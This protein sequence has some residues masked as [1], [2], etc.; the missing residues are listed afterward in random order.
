M[1]RWTGSPEGAGTQGT[2]PAVLVAWVGREQS[3]VDSPQWGGCGKETPVP[4]TGR[5]TGGATGTCCEGE[6]E[7]GYGDPACRWAGGC[8]ASLSSAGG[9]W[10]Q[11]GWTTVAPSREALRELW[12]CA[13]RL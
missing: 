7:A 12:S 8:P 6:G 13:P 9:L 4:Y 10:G 2:C 11:A 3:K 5:W 1:S